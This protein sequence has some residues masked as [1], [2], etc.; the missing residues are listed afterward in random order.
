MSQHYSWRPLRSAVLFLTCIEA[1]L[2]TVPALASTG[3]GMPW[4]PLLE[5]IVQNVGGPTLR[6]I[7]ILAIIGAGIGF[8]FAAEGSW[9]RSA[10]GLVIGFSIAAAAATWGPAFFGTAAAATP[11]TVPGQITWTDWLS[12]VC[13]LGTWMTIVYAIGGRLGDVLRCW[14]AQGVAGAERVPVP[15]TALV[16]LAG[17][18]HSRHPAPISG[19]KGSG[20]STTAP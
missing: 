12:L 20:V 9:I 10:F 3:T 15:G 8:Y 18:H 1:V 14:H 7:L 6:N 16:L 17:F 4:D 13:T 19:Q 5:A 2:G 11:G